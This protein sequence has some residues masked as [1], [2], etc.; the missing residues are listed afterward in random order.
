MTNLP[1]AT[2]WRR[3]VPT[4]DPLDP[5][6][7]LLRDLSGRGAGETLDVTVQG[8][9]VTAFTV[10][11]P[12]GVEAFVM[13]GARAVG[14]GGSF[15]VSSGAQRTLL[16]R[17]VQAGSLTVD[18]HLELQGAAVAAHCTLACGASFVDGSDSW[19]PLRV[20]H[21]DGRVVWAAAVT[22]EVPGLPLERYVWAGGYRVGA[23]RH[24]QP[25]G[26]VRLMAQGDEALRAQG[27]APEV[28]PALL[29][30]SAWL[31]RPGVVNALLDGI[32]IAG[33]VLVPDD[34]EWRES[35]YQQLWLS[36]TRAEVQR[37]GERGTAEWVD[38]S[39]WRW[40]VG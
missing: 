39:A 2:A 38:L 29:V 28:L 7:H 25:L 8:G 33:D 34:F 6:R 17:T 13:Q 23:Y 40:R 18:D 9:R 14:R 15:D 3:R 32:P 21:A 1:W 20:V 35:A 10:R 31:V 12:A 4:L 22:R 26:I 11:G 16:R 27:V 36:L 5:A 30:T 19:T 24:H 37:A